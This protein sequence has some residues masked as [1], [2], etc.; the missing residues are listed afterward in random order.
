MQVGIVGLPNVGKSTL[1]NALTK[2][3][4]KVDNYP[5]CT[6]DHHVGVVPLPDPRL[7][8][9]WEA[10]EAEKKT[11]TVVEFVD[12][13][14]L[15]KGASKGEGLGNKFLGHIREV[16]STLHVVRCFEDEQV[17]HVDGAIDPARDVETVE[18]ELLLADLQTVEK[19]MEKVGR[20]AKSGEREFQE[21]LRVLEKLC[22]AL[23]EAI[24]V[25]EIEFNDE[26][27]ETVSKHFLLTS[28]SVLYVANV[29]EDSLTANGNVYTKRLEEHLA[30]KNGKV[31]K[32]CAKLES[33]LAELASEEVNEF[34]KEMAMEEPGL[35][36]VVRE[37]YGMLNL[38]T[39]FT[40]NPKEVRGTP[41][42][43]GTTASQ[44]AGKIHTDMERGFIRAEVVPFEDF[45]RAG[46]WSQARDQ[47]LL[48]SEGR[49]YV[50][51]DGD[52]IFFRFHVL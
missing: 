6:T 10:Y 25:R 13:A 27:K 51:Q 36:R 37:C 7:D 33:E 34:L 23:N 47:G 9:L 42:V 44:A 20:Q 31:I 50:V 16:N 19:R 18:T 49:D 8:L 26:E 45:K 52:I 14:G 35:M 11:P 2:A 28:K 4:V 1:F 15:V 43:R 40:V 21:E 17:S 30:P 48:R 46:G 32:I 12:L 39:F 5:F 41:I 3:G 22:G 29:D 24:P 38:I